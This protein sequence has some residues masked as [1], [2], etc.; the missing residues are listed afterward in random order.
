MSLTLQ[1]SGIQIRLQVPPKSFGVNRWIVQMIRQLI[2]DCHLISTRA[3]VSQLT[4]HQDDP[5]SWHA[6]E[7]LCQ[8][9]NVEMSHLW[10]SQ[11]LLVVCVCRPCV[12]EFISWEC[13]Q[14]LH[15]F[16]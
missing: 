14:V 16:S 5:S 2:P 13:A 15:T 11:W 9:M 10:C 6:K 1:M 8:W 7:Y 4:Y 3:A 12:I